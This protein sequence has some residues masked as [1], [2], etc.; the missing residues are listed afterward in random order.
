MLT[1]LTTEIEHLED[2][3]LVVCTSNYPKQLDGAL[4]RRFA[5]AFKIPIP[6]AECRLEILNLLLKGTI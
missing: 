6:D 4:Q 2:G 5:K 1:Q 3:N